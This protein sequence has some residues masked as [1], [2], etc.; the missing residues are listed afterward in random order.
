MKKIGINI[1]SSKDK[2]DLILNYVYDLV[3]KEF[4][5]SELY[6]FVD[7]EGLEAEENKDLDLVIVLGGD[8][9]ILRVAR[10]VYKYGIPLL[11]VNIGHLGFLSSTELADFEKS[12]K[13]LKNK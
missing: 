13:K 10:K 1:N 2:E 11:G 5:E 12:I 9:T 6:V 4:K 8:G 3:S 7:G